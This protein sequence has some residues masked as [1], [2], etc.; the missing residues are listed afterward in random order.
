M[1][2]LITSTIKQELH[3]HNFHLKH[4]K[5]LKT[6]PIYFDLFRTSSENLVVPLLKLLHIQNLIRFCK[7]AAVAACHVVSLTLREERKLRVFE[8]GEYLD[9]GGTR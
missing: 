1:V 6:T 3:L 8:R 2:I 5:T 7:Q 4:F 9:R